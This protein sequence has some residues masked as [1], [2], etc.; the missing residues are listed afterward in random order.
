M[1]RSRQLCY[2]MNA[3]RRRR[4]NGEEERRPRVMPLLGRGI[5]PMVPR[6][7]QWDGFQ[8]ENFNFNYMAR[9]RSRSFPTPQPFLQ[10][11]CRRQLHSLPCCLAAGFGH[12]AP[13][14]QFPL[15]LNCPPLHAPN[16]P[17]YV[18][19][20]LPLLKIKTLRLKVPPQSPLTLR[21]VTPLKPIA[22]P[23]KSI[24]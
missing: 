13:N 12:V 11:H 19:P 24:I 14:A 22:A 16:P 9:E 1:G 3:K 4:E 10:I 20:L 21:M 17:H 8:E 15:R 2:A 7:Q 18:P 6:F 23:L 5:R